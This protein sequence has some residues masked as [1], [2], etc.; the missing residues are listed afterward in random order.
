MANLTRRGFVAGSALAAFEGARLI[1]G[2]E[3]TTGRR[4]TL[5]SRAGGSVGRG[6]A[7]ATALGFAIALER[8]EMWVGS[9]LYLEGA[10]LAR[11][12]GAVSVAHAH[13]GHY[14]E[15]MVLGE[16]IEAQVVDL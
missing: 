16:M 11:R 14:E 15:G 7:F 10:A 6:E 5:E 2:C 12:F 13:P 4:V 9:I 1:A 8:A 3:S